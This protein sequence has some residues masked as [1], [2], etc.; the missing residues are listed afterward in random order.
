MATQTA[1]KSC[2][3]HCHCHCRV[4]CC[5]VCLPCGVKRLSATALATYQSKRQTGAPWRRCQA[6][7]LLAVV[8]VVNLMLCVCVC[9]T[10]CNAD[11]LWQAAATAPSA[12]EAV[13]WA[14][15]SIIIIVINLCVCVTPESTLTMQRCGSKTRQEQQNWWGPSAAWPKC[16][17]APSCGRASSCAFSASTSFTSST[18]SACSTSSASSTFSPSCYSVSLCLFV[19]QLFSHLHFQLTTRQMNWF[20]GS[21]F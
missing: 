15:K 18:S 6:R 19:W 7:S 4:V 13:S 1:W 8:V 3:H 16:K 2:P 11:D 21:S 10:A 5:A 9:V 20:P 17:H 12:A 14:T